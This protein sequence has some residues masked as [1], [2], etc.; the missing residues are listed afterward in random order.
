MA[1]GPEHY[2]QAEMLLEMASDDELG[3]DA[4]RYHVAKAQAHA[5]LALAAAYAEVNPTSMWH[6]VAGSPEPAS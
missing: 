3:T 5:M 6:D 1:T 2:R 4:E